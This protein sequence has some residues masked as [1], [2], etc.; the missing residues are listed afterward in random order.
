MLRTCFQ[1]ASNTTQVRPF[2][3]PSLSEMVNSAEYGCLLS[4]HKETCT[5]SRIPEADV[6]CSPDERGLSRFRSPAAAMAVTSHGQFVYIFGGMIMTDQEEALTNAVS[7]TCMSSTIGISL[8]G[9]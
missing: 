8:I 1:I 5:W 9:T 3:P 6:D 7:R 2:L 4:V